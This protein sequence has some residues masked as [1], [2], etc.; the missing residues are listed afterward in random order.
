MKL[1]IKLFMVLCLTRGWG[2]YAAEFDPLG[3]TRRVVNQAKQIKDFRSLPEDEKIA[4]DMELQAGTRDVEL[5]GNSFV[6]ELQAVM[7]EPAEPPR[8]CRRLQNRLRLPSPFTQ[9]LQNAVC[10]TSR[11]A[12]VG[13]IVAE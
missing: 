2:L 1:Y 5:P 7:D 10:G 13:P 4:L 9:P 12:L 11:T 6:M 3:D 8:R